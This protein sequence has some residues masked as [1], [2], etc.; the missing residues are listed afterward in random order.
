MLL[1]CPVLPCS[2]SRFISSH[3]SLPCLPCPCLAMLCLAL[4]TIIP[5]TAA[6]VHP[7]YPVVV[8]FCYVFFPLSSLALP[9]LTYSIPPFNAPPC[10]AV[11]CPALPCSV[12]PH[13]ARATSLTCRPRKR[14]EG[15]REWR[16]SAGAP[17]LPVW[18]NLI[19]GY[20]G[21]FLLNGVHQVPFRVKAGNHCDFCL[22]QFLDNFI[23][24]LH[25]P[26]A[27]PPPH[28]GAT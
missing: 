24:L 12:L 5:C 10:L 1:S 16:T 11:P 15:P 13:P 7:T 25:A 17:L 9:C 8:S 27:T 21:S 19:T 3:F 2:A 23:C 18:T 14:V 6:L 20:S 22:H 28:L 4:S 26:A